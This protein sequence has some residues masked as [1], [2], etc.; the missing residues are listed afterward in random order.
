MISRVPNN[1]F[2]VL[3]RVQDEKIV[4]VV[5]MLPAR[6]RL[7]VKS[8][9]GA[10]TGSAVWIRKSL[11]TGITLSHCT[12]HQDLNKL[13]FETQVV[14]VRPGS[15]CLKHAAVRT[16]VEFVKHRRCMAQAVQLQRSSW[17]V[18]HAEPCLLHS[19]ARSAA[20]TFP[21]TNLRSLAHSSSSGN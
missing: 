3:E 20:L 6:H 10:T 2:K 13:Y 16:R 11:Y 4:T 14:R 15:R 7:S 5:D 19:V 21:D 8:Q 18:A 12:G 1:C 9:C 17:E